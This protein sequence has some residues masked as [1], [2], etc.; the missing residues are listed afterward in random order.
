MDIY[1]AIELPLV[2]V[3]AAME[4]RGVRLD[5]A[6]LQQLAVTMETAL[7]DDEKDLANV[8]QR[9]LNP[10]SPKQLRAVFYTKE[11]LDEPVRRRTKTGQPSTDRFALQLMQNQVARAVENCRETSQSLSLIVRRFP[12]FVLDDGRLH[13]SFHQAGTWEEGGSEGRPSPETGRLSSSGPNVQ[14]VT[15][16]KRWGKAIRRAFLPTEGYVFLAADASQ[17]ELRLAAWFAH[18]SALRDAFECGSDPHRLTAIRLGLDP[19]RQ[20]DIAKNCNYALIYGVAAPKLLAMVPEIGDMQAAVAIRERFFDTYRMFPRWWAAVLEQS[21]ERGYSETY[22]GRRRYLPLL[23]ARKRAD[24]L[25]AE[26]QAINHVV[27][28]TGADVLKLALRRVWDQT[29]SLDA[30]LVLT[31]HDDL[32]LEVRPS[33]IERVSGILKEAFQVLPISL[34]AEIKT[35]PTWGDLG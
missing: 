23:G 22:F 2:P 1:Q 26:R 12:S 15:A 4:D 7:T 19:E 8:A 13:P 34:P 6:Y 24:R 28:G 14:Q 5:L 25:E 29:R 9:P 10:R 27:Q 21:R 3:L 20:R 17:E 33:L 16:R 31:S 32:V 11:G 18:E 35:G 30:H